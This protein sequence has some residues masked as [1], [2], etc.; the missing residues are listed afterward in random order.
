MNTDSETKQNH[1]D[2][3]PLWLAF[4]T[5]KSE[6]GRLVD[7]IEATKLTLEL[8][9]NQARAK[10]KLLGV[11]REAMVVD[12]E[13]EVPNEMT[14]D[15]SALNSTARKSAAHNAIR[16]LIL[17]KNVS[18]IETS[19]LIKTPGIQSIGIPPKTIY[20]ALNYLAARGE[21]KRVG[22]GRYQIAE[23]G[24]GVESSHEIEHLEDN[25]QE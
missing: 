7:E 19:E 16:R 2:T 22:R 14:I 23:L 6:L 1:R 9:M 10:L 4:V 25:T 21:L 24:C 15:S 13:D 3:D 5:A 12:A 11:L 18:V 17:D 20:N 8:K